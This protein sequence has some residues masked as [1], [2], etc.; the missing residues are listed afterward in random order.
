MNDAV[1]LGKAIRE[2]RLT[3]NLRMDDVSKQVGITRATLWSIEKG[4]GNCSINTMFKV[5][6][7]LNISFS[8][9]NKEEVQFLRERASRTNTQLEKMI[10]RFVIMCVEQYASATNIESSKAYQ[11]MLSNGVIDELKNDY[12][13]LHGM[14]VVYLNNYINSLIYGVE[15]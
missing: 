15:L 2:K 5:L 14:S 6:S 11:L 4:K 13:D 3:L 1:Y 7:F 8:L 9:I 10:N 12:E